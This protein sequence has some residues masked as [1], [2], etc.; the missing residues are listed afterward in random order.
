MSSV[1][2]CDNCKDCEQSEINRGR[3]FYQKNNSSREGILIVEVNREKDLPEDLPASSCLLTEHLNENLKLDK[4]K[5]IKSIKV[6]SKSR[7]GKIDITVLF[8]LNKIKTMMGDC[9]LRPQIEPK[10]N[11]ALLEFLNMSNHLVETY[12]DGNFEG[13][14]VGPYQ[15][16]WWPATSI[17][18]WNVSIPLKP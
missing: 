1:C 6:I 14:E 17:Q 9:Y 12:F 11:E 10:L 2:W 18:F 15:S 5:M 13:I 3:L 16:E 7:G 4:F 8:T